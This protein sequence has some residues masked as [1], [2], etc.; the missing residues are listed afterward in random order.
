MSGRSSGTTNTSQTQHTDPYGPTQAGI[1]SLVSGLSGINPGLTSTETGAL[2][3]LSANAQAGNPYAPKIGDVATSLLGGGPDRT[4]IVNDAYAQY[5]GDLSPVAAGA[6]L[7]PSTNPQLQG[8]LSTIQDDVAK[9]VNGMFAG[10]GRDLSGAN[11]N[12]LGRGIA[13]GTAPVLYGAYN[14]AVNRQDAARDKLYG[15]GGATAGLL[16]GLDQ[17]SLGNQQAGI[18]AAAS[19][20]NAKDSSL[21]QTLAIEA[22]RRG[23]P[24]NTITSLLG[25]LAGIGAQFG[26]TS[27]SGTTNT[28]QQMSGAQQFALISGAL[29]NLFGGAGQGGGQP[30]P[31]SMG[32]AG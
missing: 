4:G 5:K 23:I 28:T 17:A 22:Q 11:L 25:P 12:A 18:G 20:M 30:P 14:D 7:D 27:G 26:T 3:A 9:R 1:T 19:A 21:M 31:V 13:A 2:D 24:L 6:G 15:A 32:Y 16:S 29:R 8:Y 10:A